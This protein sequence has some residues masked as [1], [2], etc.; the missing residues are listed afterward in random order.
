MIYDYEGNQPCD[1]ILSLQEKTRNR[2]CFFIKLKST[3]VSSIFITKN[4]NPCIYKR[5]SQQFRNPIPPKF[6]PHPP[7]STPPPLSSSAK[8]ST[9]S[10]ALAGAAAGSGT[11]GHETVHR[12]TRH[13]G[14]PHL[15]RVQLSPWKK[16]NVEVPQFIDIPIFVRSNHPEPIMDIVFLQVLLC[17]ILQVPITKYMQ[18]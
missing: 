18:S 4:H 17:Q 2:C 6:N 11:T 15:I 12:S 13:C 1:V 10:C 5:S 3:K 9:A 7:S 8:T 14:I 16:S